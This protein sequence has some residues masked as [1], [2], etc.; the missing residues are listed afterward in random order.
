[1]V[2]EIESTRWGL[3]TCQVTLIG[4][5]DN[6][7]HRSKKRGAVEPMCPILKDGRSSVENNRQLSGGRIF[8]K[9]STIA[10][11]DMQNISTLNYLPA[12]GSIT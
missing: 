2:P 9:D 10:I 7:L 5:L 6:K 3:S 1:M 4:A 11:V 8:R 12:L